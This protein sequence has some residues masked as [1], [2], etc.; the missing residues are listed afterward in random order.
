MRQKILNILRERNLD[1]R[2]FN[3]E[4]LYTAGINNIID[5]IE[6]YFDKPYSCESVL[7]ELFQRG[8]IE[9]IKKTNH[10]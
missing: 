1:K 4:I 6:F 10:N 9:Q 7:A 2:N 8:V 3:M 5:N